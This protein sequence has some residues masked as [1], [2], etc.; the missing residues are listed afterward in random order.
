MQANEHSCIR[1]LKNNLFFKKVQAL[2]S[3]CIIQ[4]CR[5]EEGELDVDDLAGVPQ[6]LEKLQQFS[7]T[8]Q[9]TVH[10]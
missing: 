8:G 7:L 2:G 5:L 10:H 1:N 3:S 4:V 6:K 9:V